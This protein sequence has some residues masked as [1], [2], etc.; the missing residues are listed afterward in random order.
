MRIVAWTI[1]ALIGAGALGTGSAWAQAAPNG[2]ALSLNCS[3]CHGLDGKGVTAVTPLKG[4]PADTVVAAMKQFK[5]GERPA[6]VMNRIAK[7]FTDEEIQAI[8]SYLA[9]QK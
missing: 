9:S 3:T 6:T 4:V 5:S 8:A 7:G 1:V 2:L